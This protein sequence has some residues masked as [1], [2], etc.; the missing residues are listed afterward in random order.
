MDRAFQIGF[1]LVLALGAALFFGAVTDDWINHRREPADLNDFSLHAMQ[2]R[3][4]RKM[5]AYFVKWGVALAAI[6]SGGLIALA[7]T[8]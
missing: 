1:Q 7:F 5:N 6:G 3:R 4:S 8:A 2:D